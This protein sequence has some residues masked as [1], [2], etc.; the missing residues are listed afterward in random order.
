MDKGL[1]REQQAFAAVV[2]R[3]IA[4]AWLEKARATKALATGP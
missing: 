3:A 2:G 4:T 1:S